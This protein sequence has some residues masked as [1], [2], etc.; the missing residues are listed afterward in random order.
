MD[1]LGYFFRFLSEIRKEKR[2]ENSLRI[3]LKIEIDS[4]TQYLI[5]F[6]DDL[7][8]NSIDEPYLLASKLVIKDLIEIKNPIWLNKTILTA[9]A[10][11]EEEI[12]EI[13]SFYQT[14]NKCLKIQLDL[15]KLKEQEE[16]YDNNRNYIHLGDTRR[17]FTLNSYDKW[18]SFKGSY[19]KAIEKGDSLVNRLKK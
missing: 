8:E 4:N 12:N 15:I 3:L 2:D 11:K 5:N 1:I 16:E 19:T 14:M 9:Q 17:V 18:Y 13:N 7:F 10:L 6:Y